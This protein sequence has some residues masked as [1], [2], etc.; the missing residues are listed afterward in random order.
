MR[1]AGRSARDAAAKRDALVQVVRLIQQSSGT[2]TAEQ[3]ATIRAAGYTDAQLKRAPSF[4]VGSA[5]LMA[6]HGVC[7]SR[8]A[9]A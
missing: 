2:L 8:A 4:C 9:S 5:K 7:A 6:Q 3:F 1:R